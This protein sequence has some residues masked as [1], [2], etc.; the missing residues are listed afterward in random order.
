LQIRTS[1]QNIISSR[2]GTDLFMEKLETLRRSQMF[3]IA[4][5][6]KVKI[7]KTNI[8]KQTYT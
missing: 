3:S 2:I 6:G 5:Q 7:E 8:N 1:I 4:E